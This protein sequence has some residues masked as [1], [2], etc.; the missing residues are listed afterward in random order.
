LAYVF[1]LPRIALLTG[2]E[3]RPRKP[4][5]D[6]S[7]SVSDLAAALARAGS[8]EEQERLLA[9]KKEMVNSALL[10]ALRDSC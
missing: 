5:A 9:E 3:P 2:F 1:H 4:H 8:D 7:Q 6:Q 10:A